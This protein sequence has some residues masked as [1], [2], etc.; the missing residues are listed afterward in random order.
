MAVYVAL[1]AALAAPQGFFEPTV[2]NSVIGL[3]NGFAAVWVGKCPLLSRGGGA[4][5][6]PRTGVVSAPVIF[7]HTVIVSAVNTD[8]LFGADFAFT[9]MPVAHRG[10]FVKVV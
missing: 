10:V 8:I 1:R 9:K 2:P 7:P 3:R 6:A 5:L 4:L